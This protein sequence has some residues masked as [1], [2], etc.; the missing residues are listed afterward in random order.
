MQ[1]AGGLIYPDKTAELIRPVAWR[2]W[3][4]RLLAAIFLFIFVLRGFIPAW[5]KLGS[6]FANYYLV[7]SLY[8]RGY[9]VERVY[10][11][12]WLQRQKD[13]LGID[14]ALVGFIPSTL[15]SALVV[16]PV[17]SL[18]PLKANRVWLVINLGLMLSV[19]ALLK[20][21]TG[22]TWRRIAVLILLAV[23]PLRKNFLLGQVHVVVLCLLVLAAYLYFRDQPFLSGI[24]LAI[25]AALKIYPALFLLFFLVKKEWRAISGLAIGLA[26]ACV[27]SIGLFGASACRIYLFEVLPWGLRGEVIDPYSIGWDSLSSLFHRL[28]VF[29][30]ELNPAPVAHL[31][32]LYAALHS[33]TLVS[34]LVIFLWAISLRSA[35][36]SRPKLE[37]AAYCFLLLLLSSEPL[38]YH[39]AALIL[40]AVLVVDY[41]AARDQTGRAVL[42]AAL[43]LLTCL[44]Y[45]RLYSR[46]PRGWES[47]FFFPRLSCM[48]LFAGVLLWFL[49]SSSDESSKNLLK[50]HRAMFAT[51]AFVAMTGVVFAM[52]VHHLARQFDNYGMRVS[53][54]VGSAIAVDPVIVPD[55]LLFDALVPHFH[56]S[57]HDAYVVQHLHAGS[58]TSYRGGGDWFY[59]TATNDRQAAWAEVAADKD[60]KIVRFDSSIALSSSELPTVEV[61]HAE[62]PVVSPDGTLLAYI[63]EAKGR[64][65]L[66]TRDVK[67]GEDTMESTRERELAG[68]Q[69]DVREA[70]FTPAGQII[71][72]SWRGGRYQLYSTDPETEAMAQLTAVTCS[73]RYPAVSPNGQWMA[74]SCEHRGVWQLAVMNLQTSVLRQLTA[75][76]CNSVTPAWTADSRNLIFATDCGRALGITA[77]SKLNVAP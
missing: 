29:E 53:T 6:D 37:W 38:P 56:D 61:S 15:T 51:A 43:Y 46:N 13:H 12:I 25:A 58:I 63:R 14:R 73:A 31:P 48:L 32:I 66:W 47:L 7:E 9:P 23:D 11:W 75:G 42:A 5:G 3:G 49:F 28:F 26:G 64:G 72:S 40:T 39:F 45:D 62:Q 65:S 4:E 60:S 36:Q 44:P 74:F 77:L 10:D 33:L 54:S 16:L 70:A 69:Y 59:P 67:H 8:R 20:R 76:D 41:L 18:P 71:F 21:I 57:S 52:D 2:V 1:S 30:P 22:L 17:S 19:A 50:T 34:A 27:L 55:G 24:T 68:T 35:D